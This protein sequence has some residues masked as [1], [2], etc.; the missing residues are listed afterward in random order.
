MKQV[1]KSE[2]QHTEN[3]LDIDGNRV[4]WYSLRNEIPDEYKEDFNDD[5]IFEL[6]RPWP[7][8]LSDK[9]EF[10]AVFNGQGGTMD[11][12]FLKESIQNYEFFKKTLQ[13]YSPKRI[14]E[15]GT[16]ACVFDWFCYKFLD[17]FELHTVD[18]NGYSEHFV[19]EVNNHFAKSNIHF[20]NDDS[21]SCINRLFFNEKFDLA[22]LDAGH[23]YKQLLGEMESADSL[24]IP[25][26]IID[27]F[28]DKNLDKAIN[29][30]V[31]ATSYNIVETKSGTKGVKYADKDGNPIDNKK[32]GYVKV[33]EREKD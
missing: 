27:D 17:D 1:S 28:S 10:R 7:L 2:L 31:E 13:K 23:S 3:F 18:I 12:R 5:M 25:V 24:E 30:F 15:T 16:N 22:F 21:P 19:N 32:V 26:L 6:V 20:Y 8:E 9:Y 14:L 29:D 33:L 4:D 11:Y